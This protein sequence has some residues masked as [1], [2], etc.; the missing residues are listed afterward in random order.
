MCDRPEP[1]MSSNVNVQLHA[2]FDFVTK[3]NSD[4]R[5][6]LESMVQAVG[7]IS[8]TSNNSCVFA[9]IISDCAISQILQNVCAVLRIKKHIFC[10]QFKLIL[11]QKPEQLSVKVP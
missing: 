6:K 7:E 11:V 3:A 9:G 8:V 10:F 2:S 1:D 4:F 5:E